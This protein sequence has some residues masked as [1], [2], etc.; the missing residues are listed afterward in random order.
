MKRLI[1]VAGL[2]CSGKS[3]LIAALQ[4]GELPALQRTLE[5]GDPLDWAY[6][7]ACDLPTLQGMYARQMVLH[8]DIQAQRSINGYR[9]IA[10][11]LRNANQAV[12]V[13]LYAQPE[14]LVV[15][16]WSRLKEVVLACVRQ[17]QYRRQ[18]LRRLRNILNRYL[19]YRN[20]QAVSNLYSSW[21]D[22]CLACGNHEHWVCDA[23]NNTVRALSKHDLW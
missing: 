2:S 3:T 11:L 6:V 20:R 9:Y 19:V 8:Y 1:V 7:Q 10:G 5:I 22:F 4:R 23:Q 21:F 17:P 13:T 14:V 18:F 16:N 15:R 12:F